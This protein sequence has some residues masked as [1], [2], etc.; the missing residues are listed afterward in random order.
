MINSVFAPVLRNPVSPAKP[1]MWM[2]VD[3]RWVW[4]LEGTPPG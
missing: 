1:P 4:V 3:G 2:P